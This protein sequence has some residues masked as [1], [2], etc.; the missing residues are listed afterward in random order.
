M[1][2]L[3]WT[4]GMPLAPARIAFVVCVTPPPFG[5]AATMRIPGG[6]QTGIER[7]MGGERPATSARPAM[8]EAG[9]RKSSAVLE[10]A[11]AFCFPGGQIRT[12]VS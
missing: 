12:S 9:R 8:R 5:W 6:R 1:A 4:C 7:R 3:S 2:G 11:G 10:R